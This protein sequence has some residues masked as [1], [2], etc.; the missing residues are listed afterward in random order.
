MDDPLLAM[1][2]GGT[3]LNEMWE[4]N[5]TDDVDVDVDVL[6][7]AFFGADGDNVAED[8]GLGF[9]AEE[10]DDDN[11]FFCPTVGEY[12]TTTAATRQTGEELT[13]PTVTLASSQQLQ[14]RRMKDI[15]VISPS[16]NGEDSPQ[17]T[18]YLPSQ[19]T[20]PTA[21]VAS[22][23]EWPAS[24]IAMAAGMPMSLPT[25]SMV[26]G[27]PNQQGF[28]YGMPDS[29]MNG[30]GMGQQAQQVAILPNPFLAMA[31]GM[32]MLDRAK[33]VEAAFAARAKNR[34][35]QT[36]ATQDQAEKRRERNRVLAKKTRDRKKCHMTELQEELLELQKA[37]AELKAMV[38]NNIDEKDSMPLLE[39]CQAIDK[40]P[41]SVWEACGA[42]KNE[43]AAEDY[44]LVSSIQKSQ[45]AFVI[46][47][48]SFE[49]NPIVFVSPDFLA[50]TGYTR[51]QV[52]GRNCRFL[53]GEATDQ[54][55]VD[56]IR[57]ALAVGE[58]IGITLINYKADGT[59]FWNR[60]FIAA[61][62]D[63]KDN[64]VNYMSVS[65]QVSRP[66]PEDPEYETELPS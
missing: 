3:S 46:T 45:T 26:M 50:M 65:V 38:R 61:V 64:I 43:L 44:D 14:Q 24:F 33:F 19:A 17:A 42:D 23:P 51:E 31:A 34:K 66:E 6:A 40:V 32:P 48:P 60:L 55:K 27:D 18:Q 47:D 7:E 20:Q 53:Q 12:T 5:M 13:P 39:Q 41:K 30:N 52:V 58:D 63:V 11:L 62:R 36:S 15:A 1:G 4:A 49:D 29:L 10:E 56:Q 28:T 16:P 9:N 21:A 54:D 35:R 57:H 22:T 37:N 8:S 2:S 25:G 59:A